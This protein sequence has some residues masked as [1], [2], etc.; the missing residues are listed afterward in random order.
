MKRSKTAFTALLILMVV[1]LLAACSGGGGETKKSAEPSGGGEANQSAESGGDEKV[2]AKLVKEGVLTYGT[3]ATFPPYEYM[4]NGELTGFDIELGQALADELG[5]DVE[6]MAMNF[7]GLIPALQGGRVDIINSAMYIKPERE[8]QVDFIPYMY[9]GN[10]VVVLKGNKLNISS[11]NDL[12]GLKVA[13]TRG[14]VEEIYANEQNER[15]EQAGKKPMEILALPTA[16]DAVLATEQGRADAFLHS[17]PGAAY[18]LQE[19]PG[20]FEIA[21]TFDMS[22]E[23]GIAVR[24]GDTAM[25]QTI[26]EALQKVVENGTY[27]EL[28]KKYNLPE[29]LSYFR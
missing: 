21:A 9:I 27:A 15:F 16:N 10:A 23:I 26:E 22:T 4:A 5:L 24:K 14:G 7:E 28:M 19:K 2:L 20:V 11:L 1:A 17:S 8:E 13:V 29:A 3:A 18:L 12:T 25:K 6:I